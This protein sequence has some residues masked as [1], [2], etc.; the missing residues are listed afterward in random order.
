MDKFHGTWYA[1]RSITHRRSSECT[2]TYQHQR[3]TKPARNGKLY[4]LIHPR[5]CDAH[6]TTSRVDK[7]E[8]TLSMASSSTES[9]ENIKLALSEA[10][11]MSYFDTNKETFVTVDASPVGDSVQF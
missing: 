6:C 7:K 11:V 8:Y 1:A 10:P 2:D 4:C 3:G 5:F 9:I